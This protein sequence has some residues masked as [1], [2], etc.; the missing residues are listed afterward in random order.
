MISR[1]GKIQKECEYCGKVFWG[2]PTKKYCGKKCAAKNSQRKDTLCW[3][4]SK[5]TGLGNCPWANHLIPVEGWEAIPT[6]INT[7]T[8]AVEVVSYNVRKC[9]LF[10][11]G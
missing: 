2:V 3:D 1:K 4:C 8:L 11:R 9:P 5:A 10:E 7:N 6:K